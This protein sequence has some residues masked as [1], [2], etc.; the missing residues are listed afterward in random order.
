MMSKYRI[1]INDLEKQGGIQ[2]L[3]KDG[4]KRSEI[5]QSFYK[6]TRGA[7]KKEREQIV[8][9]LYDRHQ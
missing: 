8:H 1:S 2:K 3:E 9:R 5:W 7:S 6:E 4:F